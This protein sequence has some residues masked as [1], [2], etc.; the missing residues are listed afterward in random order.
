L[1]VEVAHIEDVIDD[2]M[3]HCKIERK[4]LED[5]FKVFIKYSKDRFNRNEEYAIS[6]NIGIFYK[7]LDKDLLNKVEYPTT[8]QEKY[9][10]AIFINR[11]L[12]PT[13]QTDYCHED[14]EIIK[15]NTNNHLIKI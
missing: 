1:E 10:E 11:R 9:N 15:A 8:K 5:L 4:D 2:Y 7:A 6:T 13:A 12:K 3:T 14:I